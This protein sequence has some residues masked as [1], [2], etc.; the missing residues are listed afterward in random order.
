M[1]DKPQPRK[2]L[3]AMKS[4][5]FTRNNTTRKEKTMRD[6]IM[7]TIRQNVRRTVLA[8][9]ACLC[10]FAFGLAVPVAF[11]A[12]PSATAPAATALP[13]PDLSKPVW[14]IIQCDKTTPPTLT[15]EQKKTVGGLF[16]GP[17]FGWPTGVGFALEGSRVTRPWLSNLFWN[18]GGKGPDLNTWS[19]TPISFLE[20][21]GQQVFKDTFSS[22]RATIEDGRLTATM[23]GTYHYPGLHVP[24][25]VVFD[26]QLNG[27]LDGAKIEGTWKGTISGLPLQGTCVGAV[28]PAASAALDPRNAVYQIQFPKP[29]LTAVVEVRDGKGV[30]G[31]ARLLPSRENKSAASLTKTLAVDAAGLTV[32]VGE[33]GAAGCTGTLKGKVAIAGLGD[34]AIGEIEV[35]PTGF[36]GSLLAGAPNG[37]TVGVRAYPIDDPVASQWKR[38]MQAIWNGTA[39]VEPAL[40]DQAR[41]DADARVGLPPPGQTTQFLH[42]YPGG[43]EIPSFIYAP[44]FDFQPVTGAKQYRFAIGQATFEA[45]EPTA[46]LS[47]VWKDLPVGNHTVTLT[48]LDADGKPLGE[49]QKRRFDKRAPFGGEVARSVT[50]EDLALELALRYPRTLAARHYGNI[51]SLWAVLTSPP[52]DPIRC[53]AIRITHD[54]FAVLARWSADPAERARAAH[55]AEVWK[56]VYIPTLRSSPLGTREDYYSF[57]FVKETLNNYLSAHEATGRRQLLDEA[58]HW[59]AVHARLIQPNGSWTWVDYTGEFHKGVWSPFINASS[60]FGRSTMDHDAAPYVNFF[61]RLRKI[62][63]DDRHRDTE[64]KGA[65]WL[66]H[67]GL[68]TG[69]WPHQQQQSDSA[70][71]Y[72]AN[73]MAVESLEYLLERAPATVGSVALAEDLARSIEDRWIDWGPVSVVHGGNFFNTTPLPM[74]VNYLRLYRATGRPIYRAKAEALFHSYLINRDPVLGLPPGFLGP[75]IS[76]DRYQAESDDPAWALRYLE[77]RRALD[78]TP[79]AKPLPPDGAV[80]VLRLQHGVAKAEPIGQHLDMKLN[81]LAS[82]APQRAADPV[83]VYLDVQGGKV[84]QAIA[85]TPT[86]DGPILDYPQPGRLHWQEGMALFHTVDASKLTVGPQG[87][88][89]EVV[90]QLKAPMPESKPVATTFRIEATQDG[91]VWSGRHDGGRVDGEMRPSAAA[92]AGRL[93]FE[94]DRAVTGGEPWQNWAL[95]QLDLPG[96]TAMPGRAPRWLGNGNAGWSAEV[97]TAEVALTDTALSGT[98]KAKVNYFGFRDG[99]KEDAK[100]HLTAFEQ[101]LSF[102]AYWNTSEKFFGKKGGKSEPHRAEGSYSM[103]IT[104]KPL[105]EHIEYVTSSKPVTP[106]DYEYRFTG[107]RLGDVVAGTVTIKGPDGKEHTCQFLGGVE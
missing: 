80:T 51:V 39:P 97:Q 92:K 16:N 8:A 18:G 28:L 40:A 68:R 73:V 55:L 33:P 4:D 58:R 11:A 27:T 2:D 100:Y 76:F 1:K 87:I 59:A 52:H 44:W 84:R 70:D 36:G 69:Y 37:S 5:M 23:K 88:G 86:W 104:P 38:W 48:A 93:W 26:L 66:M 61:G 65:H 15:E 102:L 9:L 20:I 75:T 71:S 31:L 10:M 54:P 74:A 22:V 7:T 43:P 24:A 91:R 6:T 90:V 19:H 79:P 12:E 67:N 81:R 78:T 107:H 21:S 106:G 77:L 82:P 30:S 45:A 25:P 83:F 94:V 32:S 42:R 17:F 89:G 3:F 64:L 29:N 56:T 35:S 34:L 50:D 47:P 62:T 53:Y 105:G 60:F 14:V 41:A 98:M 96:A 46:W 101:G 57:G 63:G 13:K 99:L 85:T 103:K 95:A 72:L 49:P